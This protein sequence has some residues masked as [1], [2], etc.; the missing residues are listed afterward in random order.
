M[1]EQPENE[2][3]ATFDLVDADNDQLISAGEL[4]RLME[5]MGEEMTDEAAARAVGAVDTDGD[6]RISL[7]EFT[8]FLRQNR[9]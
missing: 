8:A 1:A 7:V 3:A 4:K 2:Y 9:G 6:G 5:V